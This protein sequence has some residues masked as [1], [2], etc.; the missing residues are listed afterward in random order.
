MISTN[1]YLPCLA[2]LAI[3][4][5]AFFLFACRSTPAAGKPVS[6]PTPTPTPQPKPF[7][8]FLK[9]GD[10]WAIRTDGT[11][12]HLLALAPEDESIQDFVWSADGSRVYYSAGLKF[13][14]VVIAT[15]NIGAAG[16]FAAPPDVTIDRLAMGR[17]GK[18]LV[19]DA[20]NAA[21]ETR[22]YA[23][24]IGQREARELS[25][26]EHAALLPPRPPIVRSLDDKSV[27]PDARWVLF[28][29]IVGTGEELFIA[30][31]ETGARLQISNLYALGGFEES[32]AIEGGRRLMEAAW[33]PD[34]RYVIFNPMQYCSE[35]GICAGRLYLVGGF[36]GPQLQLSV[37]TMA[38]LP[39]EWTS[40]GSLLI[41]DD[42]NRVV[43][44]DMNGTPKALADGNHPKCQPMP[45]DRKSSF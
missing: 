18:T 35:I 13:S 42:S 25:F 19:V 39:S 17:D 36:G 21:A 37:D 14:E 11:D 12:E 33:S 3:C 30:S 9:E 20:L 31:S 29:A 40:D 45:E 6:S 44:A 15:S 32:V 27:S 38:A 43:I 28:K 34:G 41:Y 10:L 1:R 5:C 24:T 8:A 16:E 7:I 26:D 22:H 23:V 4:L 2:G